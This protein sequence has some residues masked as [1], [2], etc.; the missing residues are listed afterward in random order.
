MRKTAIIIVMLFLPLIAFGQGV[1][2]DTYVIPVASHT[3]GAF[4]T[5]WRSDVAIT[6]FQSTPLTVQIVVVESGE[7]NP[8]NVFAL[9][10]SSINGSVSIPANSTVL[11]KDV[12]NS[13]RGLQN[14]AGALIVGAG[15]PFAIT[16]RTYTSGPAGTVGETVTPA[17][18][19]FENA[20]GRSDNTAV[21]YI[22]GI[23]NNAQSRTNIGF[24]AATGSASGAPMGV[25]VTIKDNS[26]KVLGTKLILIPAANF[27]QTQ[28]SVGSITS[29]TFDTGVAELRIVQGS[30]AVVPYASVVDNVTGAASYIAGQFPP[31]TAL[32]KTFFT[33][34][35]LRAQQ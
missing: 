11:L 31:S 16:S 1:Y 7:G 19:F 34:A 22:P 2:S 28:F 18:D 20:T 3:P 30:G 6:N 29:L 5:V 25:Q 12:L 32:A 4:G 35:L 9:T 8:D 26:G 21:A 10:S 17:R 27:T 13:H 23:A 14:V 15:A 24:L 33:N